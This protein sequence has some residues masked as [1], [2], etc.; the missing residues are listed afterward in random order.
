MVALKLVPVLQN[1]FYFL[2][3]KQAKK[4]I[5]NMT[6]FCTTTFE[7]FMTI[8]LCNTAFNYILILQNCIDF[9]QSACTQMQHTFLLSIAKDHSQ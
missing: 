2:K 1:V 7:R 3:I 8:Q 5:K 9:S 4:K 6:Q